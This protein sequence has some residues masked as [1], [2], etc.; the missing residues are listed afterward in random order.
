MDGVSGR[1]QPL[2]SGDHPG[3]EPQYGMEQN[4]LGH[5]YSSQEDDIRRNP[6]PFR[7]RGLSLRVTSGPPK[8]KV[9]QG[10]ARGEIGA[11]CRNSD[12]TSAPGNQRRRLTLPRTLGGFWV[13]HFTAEFARCWPRLST[14]F[15][16]SQPVLSRFSV[17]SHTSLLIILTIRARPDRGRGPY[18]RRYRV[19]RDG[20]SQE[21][22]AHYFTLRH[23]PHRRSI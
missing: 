23:H 13:P 19:N 9:Q 12:R 5:P 14:I 7:K 18:R 4:H 8:E 22:L 10:S 21:R 11:F 3:P 1:A 16:K 15:P 6:R 17:R 20:Q 2:G